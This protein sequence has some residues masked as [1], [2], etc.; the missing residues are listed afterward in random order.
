MPIDRTEFLGVEFDRLTQRQ[1]I[2]FLH[3][4]TPDSP[5]GY[6]V[7]PN[8]DHMVR[9]HDGETEAGIAAAYADADLCVCDSRVL[10]ALARMRGLSLPTVTGSDLTAALLEEVLQPGDRVAVVGGHAATVE[11]LSIRYP[12]LHFVHHSPPMGLRRDGGA[13]QAAADFIAAS[14][15]RFTFLAV[16]SPQQEM[17]AA[18]VKGAT[19][20]ALCIGAALEFLTGD[21]LRAP[22][23]L[24]K[25][26]MEWAYRLAS[27][28]RRLWRRYLIEGPKIFLLARR[29]KPTPPPSRQGRLT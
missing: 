1:V 13:R 14:K 26:G 6:I 20:F 9:L 23:A 12:Q 28:P 8:V 16:G 7:T 22:R 29:W 4:V 3:K 2:D 15:C 5:F 17:I 10:S 18:E 25:I 21:Q 19:G 24:Q 27:N 11:R